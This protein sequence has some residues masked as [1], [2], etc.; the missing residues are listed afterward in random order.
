[1]VWMLSLPQTQGSSVRGL[2]PKLPL[3]G[4]SRACEGQSSGWSSDHRGHALK[5]DCGI[6]DPSCFSLLHPAY[7]M[8]SVAP[9]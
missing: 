1:M 2:L 4:N 5:G 9:P 6:P 7:E 8:S 3:L